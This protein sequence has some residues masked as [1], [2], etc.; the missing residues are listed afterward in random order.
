MPK[1][2]KH[3]AETKKLISQKVKRAVREGKIFTEEYRKK[4]SELKKGHPTSEETKRKIS[5]ANKGKKRTAEQNRANS[6]RMKGSIPWNKGKKCP[7]AK[8][9]HYWGEKHPMWKG[10]DASPEAMHHWVIK[11]KG[12]PSK[13]EH[14]GRTDKK[15]YEWANIDHKYRRRLEDY[16][17]LCT[18]CHRKY[19]IENNNYI[20]GLNKINN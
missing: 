20:S 7:W 5:L 9:P 18:S 4:M 6:E 8:P 11:R 17:R 2:Y 1:G 16:I 12:T 14:C 19:D 3:T 13:C 15:R 10:D